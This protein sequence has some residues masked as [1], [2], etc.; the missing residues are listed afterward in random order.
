MHLRNL[1]G[2]MDNVTYFELINNKCF[3]NVTCLKI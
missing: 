2:R 1:I 3:F